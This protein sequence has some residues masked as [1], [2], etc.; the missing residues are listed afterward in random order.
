TYTAGSTVSGSAGFASNFAWSPI[1]SYSY[2]VGPKVSLSGT[3]FTL[4]ALSTTDYQF[5]ASDGGLTQGIDGFDSGF[6]RFT[7]EKIVFGYRDGATLSARKRWTTAVSAVSAAATAGGE[8]LAQMVLAQDDLDSGGG[9]VLGAQNGVT[10]A[11]ILAFGLLMAKARSYFNGDHK[12]LAANLQLPTLVIE[13]AGITLAVG[14]STIKLTANGIEISA[15]EVKINAASAAAPLAF[16]ADAAGTT[17]AGA[18]LTLSA[19][20]N[21]TVTPGGSANITAGGAMLLQGSSVTV[22]G[23]TTFTND[24]NGQKVTCSEIAATTSAFAK[25]AEAELLVTRL[26]TLALQNTSALELLNAQLRSELEAEGL[27]RETIAQQVKVLE[28]LAEQV[29]RV[30]TV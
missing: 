8:A 5:D 25:K 16:K 11:S 14:T 2:S 28:A 19:T 1:G 4:G 20:N 15:D 26:E 18:A 29:S 24:L 6:A 22:T 13:Q 23:G 7:N 21:L 27:K 30:L 3:P 9:A 10:A 17:L 12:A